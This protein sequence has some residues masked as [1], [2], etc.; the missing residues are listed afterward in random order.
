M[1]TAQALRNLFGLRSS[2]DAEAA[3][4]QSRSSET[5]AMFSYYSIGHDVL[6]TGTGTSD[7]MRY[8]MYMTTPVPEDAEAFVQQSVVIYVLDL[9]FNTQAHLLGV[10]SSHSINRLQ[11]ET[12]LASVGMAKVQLDPDFAK[13]CSIF[14]GRDHDF[15]VQYALDPDAIKFVRKYTRTHLW[16]LHDSELYV[17]VP[18]TSIGDSRFVIDSHLFV[19]AIRPALPAPRPDAVV[20][21]REIPYTVY[22][23]PALRCPICRKFMELQDTAWFRCPSGHGMLVTDRELDALSNDKLHQKIDL[24]AIV[25]HGPLTCPHCHH[26]MEIVRYN[27]TKLEINAC[28]NCRFKWVDTDD[29]SSLSSLSLGKHFSK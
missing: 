3:A 16:E 23:G 25:H 21:H 9:P 11:F 15:Q 12:Y 17:F 13:D 7:G 28:I 24:T 6:N 22:D 19:E 14:T 20:V 4:L 1:N 27:G 5:S 18:E 10:S 26:G 29:A 2:K 8:G